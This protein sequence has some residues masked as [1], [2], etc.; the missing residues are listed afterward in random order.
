[1]PTPSVAYPTSPVILSAGQIITPITP[2]T[3]GLPES[4]TITPPTPPG[5]FFN[6]LTGIISGTPSAYLPVTTYTVTF[7]SNLGQ[8]TTTLSLT[9][10]SALPLGLTTLATVTL[11]AQQRADMVNSGFITPAE[12]T[13]MINASY[14]ELYG[15]LITAYG[16]DWEFTATYNFNSDGVNEMFALPSDTF[17]IMGVDC[18]WQAGNT[19]SNVTLKRFNMRERNR[20][21]APF[22]A[23]LPGVP[24]IAPMYRIQGGNIWF[25]PI[26]AVLPFMVYYAPRLQILVNP[27]DTLDG[28]NGWEEYIVCDAAIKA[29]QKEESD[30]SVLMAQK[31]ALLKRINDEAANRDIGDPATVTDVY[32]TGGYAGSYTNGSW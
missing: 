26:P 16:E 10:T 23:A 5:L 30:C 13:S 25:K 28:V 15:I 29:M 9:I 7:N 24:F 14:Q 17:K 4:F 21:A 22:Y 11:Q 19:S 6:P 27:T 18:Q 32:A 2:T 3:V 8:A 1:M 31:M 12:W 20:F